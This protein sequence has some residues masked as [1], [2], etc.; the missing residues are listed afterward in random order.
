MKNALLVVGLLMGFSAFG[1]G[2]STMNRSGIANGDKTNQIGV[3][4][5]VGTS[6]GINAEYWV[7]QSR[8]WTGA[9]AQEHNNAAVAI[10]Q[11]MMFRDFFSGNASALAPY[12]GVGAM[13]VFGK[14]SDYLSRTEAN[15]NFVLAAQVPVGVEWLPRTQRFSLFGQLTPSAEVTPVLMGFMGADL[16]GR[17]YF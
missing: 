12:I 1:Q 6:T 15:D 2:S 16:G 5:Q 13:G 9:I 11:N 8:A 14:N 3:G 7:D 17:F 10:G 4:A